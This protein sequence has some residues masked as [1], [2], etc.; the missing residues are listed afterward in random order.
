[1]TEHLTEVVHLPPPPRP[2]LVALAPEPGPWV[3]THTGLAMDLLN[4]RVEDVHYQ[5][6]HVA[7]ARAPRFAGHTIEPFSVGQ[8]SV[9]V[10]R[11]LDW[12][13][14]ERGHVVPTE[15]RL[16]TLL[17]DAHEAYMGDIST[18]VSN[19]PG[20]ARPI[21]ALK[22]RLQRVIHIAFGLPAALP[23]EWLRMIAHADRVALAT[24]KR[25]LMAPEPKPWAAL[26]ESA[27]VDLTSF[28]YR[29]DLARAWRD[30]LTALREEVKS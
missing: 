11:I 30:D 5:D 4:P 23:D 15:M 22:G 26:P 3:Q 19:L 14:M 9:L 1:M 25:D 8:H 16:A 21:F 18:P 13:W 6:I 27:P 2:H 7:L 12:M 24:E 17:H 28:A 20:L 29:Y 10:M